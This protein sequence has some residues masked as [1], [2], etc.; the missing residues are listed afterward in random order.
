MFHSLNKRRRCETLQAQGRVLLE[1]VEVRYDIDIWIEDY[2]HPLI[3][4]RRDYVH[5][6]I[7]VWHQNLDRSEHIRL[8]TKR[9]QS[10]D[11]TQLGEFPYIQMDVL[12]EILYD[13]N[14]ADPIP[15]D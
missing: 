5:D 15:I 6:E 12:R 4:S 14:R 9:N 10:I 2:W 1:E 3:Q 11:L 7:P 8:V 13:N